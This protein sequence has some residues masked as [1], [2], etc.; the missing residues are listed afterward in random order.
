VSRRGSIEYDLAQALRSTPSPRRPAD[1]PGR[2]RTLSAPRLRRSPR[3]GS[4]RCAAAAHQ[5]RDRLAHGG[6]P[7][8]GALAD[9]FVAQRFAQPGCP[10]RCMA[11]RRGS[12]GRPHRVLQGQQAA[13]RVLFALGRALIIARLWRRRPGHD[14]SSLWEVEVE[15]PWQ[16]GFA[17]DRR[18]CVVEASAKK[19]RQRPSRISLAAGSPALGFADLGH[20]V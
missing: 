20:W 18:W 13:D 17:H 12:S 6:Q 10:T 14:D 4:G 7:F 11:M 3:R 9:A 15:L 19:Q 8:D 16:P 5:A 1:R 2:W